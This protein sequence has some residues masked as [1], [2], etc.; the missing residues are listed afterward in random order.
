[1]TTPT[2]LVTEAA[3]TIRKQ[4]AVAQAAVERTAAEHALAVEHLD[5]LRSIAQSV[6]VIPAETI[7]SATVPVEQVRPL[8]CD[9]DPHERVTLKQFLAD[10]NRP[11]DERL[12]S[13]QVAKLGFQAPNTAKQYGVVEDRIFDGTHHVHT[14]PRHVWIDTL[15]RLGY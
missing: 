12:D 13:D 6:G 5:T 11:E 10:L 8:Y 2:D 7:E 15:H 14:W 3:E 4:I 9:L 1:M